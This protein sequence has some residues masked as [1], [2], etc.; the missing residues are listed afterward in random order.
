MLDEEQLAT[1]LSMK[2]SSVGPARRR[3]LESLRAS[4]G[5]RGGGR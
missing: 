5:A 1:R 3:C 4:L 2:R